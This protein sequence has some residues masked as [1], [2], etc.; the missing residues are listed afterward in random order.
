MD[1]ASTITDMAKAQN[2]VYEVLSDVNSRQDIMDERI[3]NL[4]DRINSI[5]VS[6][7]VLP[8]VLSRCV[9]QQLEQHS[10]LQQQQQHQQ[11]SN[12]MQQLKPPNQQL[13]QPSPSSILSNP[14]SLQQQQ[15]LLPNIGSSGNQ[16]RSSAF[17][18]GDFA[19]LQLNAAAG[20][21]SESSGY[22]L[23]QLLQCGGSGSLPES[24][25]VTGSN[26]L[27]AQLPLQQQ[28]VI[29][30]G[31]PQHQR[32]QQLPAVGRQVTPTSGHFLPNPT[33]AGG[34]AALTQPP[35]TGTPY[36]QHSAFS[37]PPPAYQQ[38][39]PTGS[40]SLQPPVTSPLVAPNAASSVTSKSQSGGPTS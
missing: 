24:R 15:Q 5:Q 28:H 30:P 1:N 40:S 13:L 4:E 25:L 17:H 12:Q 35:S 11:H 32:G 7:D 26:Q 6:L 29:T 2:N 22:S 36:S 27:P 20:A 23:S 31:Q 37:A 14:G 18:D 3:A 8:D 16:N 9:Q 10:A 38:L 19:S 34:A 39:V 33:G 21:P